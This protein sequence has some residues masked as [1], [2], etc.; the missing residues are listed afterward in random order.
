M[1]QNR[2]RL[3]LGSIDRTQ[4]IISR[5]AATIYHLFL[6]EDNSAELFGQL[7]RIH[8]MF[9]YRIVNNVV[10]YANPVALFPRVLD[11]F[12]AQP[13]GTRSLLQH[14]FG[15]AIQDGI[16]NIQKSMNVLVTYK[17]QE[18]D[19]PAKIQA[20]VDADD[21]IKQGVKSEAKNKNVD[22]VLALLQSNQFGSTLSYDQLSQAEDAHQAWK[23][24]VENVGS[25]RTPNAELFAHL[26]QLLKLYLRLR[27]KVKMLEVINEVRDL[28]HHPHRAGAVRLLLVVLAMHG[29]YDLA[30]ELSHLW[31]NEASRWR[32]SHVQAPTR[33]VLFLW[34]CSLF[35]IH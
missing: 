12:M 3:C 7:K 10:Q 15:M 11:I 6:A 23:N 16:N 20:Y 22:L 19:F 18:P 31:K 28:P 9:P 14:I 32:S 13:F 5:I 2:V 24:A 33:H 4:L 26:K 8:S 35:A 30:A 1:A 27:D 21:E 34:K 29:F 25:E 17:I